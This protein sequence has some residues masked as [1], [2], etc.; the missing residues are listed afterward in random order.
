MPAEA[1]HGVVLLADAES[2]EVK[3][4]PVEA[5]LQDDVNIGE[6]LSDRTRKRRQS[7]GWIS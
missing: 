5:D 2:M 6:V 4:R 3:V 1:R 7:I